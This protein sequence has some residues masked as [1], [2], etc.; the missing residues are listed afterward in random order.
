MTGWGSRSRGIVGLELKARGLNVE[1][2]VYPDEGCFDVHAEV[3]VT[4][5][6]ES[7]YAKVYVAD[8]GHLTWMRDYGDE[9]SATVGEPGS[10][11]CITRSA[12]VASAVVETIMPVMSY[13]ADQV[14]SSG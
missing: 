3:M 10:C 2:A 12:S 13:L 9:A 6:D 1:L 14:G 5:P 11:E 4:S 8:D 7:G